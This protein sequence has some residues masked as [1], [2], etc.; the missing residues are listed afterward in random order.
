MKWAI[1]PTSKSNLTRSSITEIGVNKS[2]TSE[3]AAASAECND[4]HSDLRSKL[5]LLN[6]SLNFH[7]L[8]II[9]AL[10]SRRVTELHKYCGHWSCPYLLDGTTTDDT[11]SCSTISIPPDSRIHS[12]II[13]ERV[14]SSTSVYD[15]KWSLAKNCNTGIVELIVANLPSFSN[16]K[17]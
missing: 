9:D 13:I 10:E 15:H 12:T 1:Y 14:I 17:T 16:H 7:S 2:F 3:R 6:L 5:F 11:R 4:P 8:I